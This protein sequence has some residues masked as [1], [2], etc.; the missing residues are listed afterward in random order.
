MKKLTFAAVFILLTLAPVKALALAE[1]AEYACVMDA[2]TGELIFEKNAYEQHSM[3]STTKIMTALVALEKSSPEDVVAI[4]TNADLQEGSSAYLTAGSS[5][6]MKDLLYGLM[7][8]SGNDAAVA[9]AEHIS[10]GVE[11]FAALMTERAHE[12]GAADTSF[13]NPSGLDADGHYTTARDLALITREALKNPNFCEIVSSRTA[14]AKTVNSGTTLYFSNHNKLL[15]LY[16]GCIGVKTGYTKNTGRCLVSAAERGGM[17]FIAVTLDDPNDWKDHSEMLDYA[18]AECYPKDIISEGQCV[19][20]ADINGRSYSFVSAGSFTV[21]FRTKQPK[22][23]TVENH[24][25]GEMPRA[26][27]KGEKVGYSAIYYGDE[28]IGS[29]D[30]I[31]N[32][33]I[34]GTDNIRLRNSFIRK[35]GRVLENL[36]I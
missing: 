4:S 22:S 17:T 19:K 29:V 20:K 9:V 6:Y 27:N 23:Y 28:L 3:A 18:F 21:T 30:I 13:V 8:N 33:D 32:E 24:I 26:I 12:I 15:A 10:G 2:I 5:V 35:L 7:L 1:S 14:Q 16:E 36:I 25:V 11:P 31:S 34:Y